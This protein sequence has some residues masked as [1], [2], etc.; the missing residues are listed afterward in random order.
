LSILSTTF[1][2]IIQSYDPWTITWWTKPHLRIVWKIFQKIGFI[3]PTQ[4]PATLTPC[5]LYCQW[6]SNCHFQ[7]LETFHCYKM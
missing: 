7:C 5:V 3:T 4:D 6:G 1:Q 2:Q